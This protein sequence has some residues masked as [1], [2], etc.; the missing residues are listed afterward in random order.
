M[1]NFLFAKSI[2]TL[3]NNILRL[4]IGHEELKS[5]NPWGLEKLDNTN[6]SFIRVLPLK[7]YLYASFTQL[8]LIDIWDCSFFSA[9]Q[10]YQLPNFTSYRCR[11]LHVI[12]VLQ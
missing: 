1:L 6:K 11:N 9:K 4:R 7:L 12:I 5:S 10:T 8:T 2:S 3:V